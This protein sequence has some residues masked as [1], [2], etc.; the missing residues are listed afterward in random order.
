VVGSGLH[1][2]RRGRGAATRR[3]RRRSCGTH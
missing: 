3:S 1:G 2:R